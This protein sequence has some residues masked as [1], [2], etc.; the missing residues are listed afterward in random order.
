MSLPRAAFPLLLGLATG[1]VVLFLTLPVV[2]IF[3]DTGPGNLLDSLGDP[4]RLSWDALRGHLRSRAWRWSRHRWTLAFRSRLL[5]RRG[6]DPATLL[7]VEPA[8]RA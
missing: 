2:A 7:L 1:A 5:A 3:V 6:A 4:S 8:V